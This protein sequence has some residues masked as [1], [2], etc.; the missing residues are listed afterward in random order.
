MGCAAGDQQ[1]RQ[2]CQSSALF[3][4][5]K[6]L[7]SRLAGMEADGVLGRASVYPDKAPGKASAFQELTLGRWGGF[8]S[9]L[10]TSPGQYITPPKKKISEHHS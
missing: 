2:Q 3:H 5:W 8:C 10:G 9:A 1:L 4:T 6:S 7:T